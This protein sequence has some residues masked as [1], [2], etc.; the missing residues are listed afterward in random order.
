MVIVAVKGLTCTMTL[1]TL[2][3][4]VLQIVQKRSVR[5]S[6]LVTFMIVVVCC[7]ARLVSVLSW[8]CRPPVCRTTLTVSRW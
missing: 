2:I 7:I 1:N 4:I 5:L 8:S 6:C 3:S